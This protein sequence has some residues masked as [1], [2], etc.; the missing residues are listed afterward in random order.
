MEYFKDMKTFSDWNV[1]ATVFSIFQLENYFSKQ[2]PVRNR[3][4]TGLGTHSDFW[5]EQIKKV[6]ARTMIIFQISDITQ[7]VSLLWKVR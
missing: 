5:K 6:N 2:F 7:L 1:P 4:N 3:F